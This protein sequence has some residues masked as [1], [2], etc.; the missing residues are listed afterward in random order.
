MRYHDGSSKRKAHDFEQPVQRSLHLNFM[1]VPK[2]SNSFAQKV[3]NFL[4]QRNGCW[5]SNIWVA[6]KRVTNNIRVEEHDAQLP[7]DIVIELVLSRLHCA[8]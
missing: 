4:I 7:V 8:R 2:I 5:D 3:V 6:S 1:K